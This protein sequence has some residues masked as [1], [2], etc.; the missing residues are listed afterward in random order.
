MLFRPGRNSNSTS[1]FARAGG[2][3]TRKNAILIPKNR[4]TEITLR[5]LKKSYL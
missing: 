5:Y 1:A 4:L 2:P 3:H